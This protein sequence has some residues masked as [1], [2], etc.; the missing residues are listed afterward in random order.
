MLGKSPV[1]TLKKVE[2]N[3]KRINDSIHSNSET[4]EGFLGLAWNIHKTQ[5]K[6]V[7]FS[8]FFKEKMFLKKCLKVFG[9]DN[10][11][12]SV[13]DCVC[14]IILV[15]GAQHSLNNSDTILASDWSIVRI[16]A[17]YWSITL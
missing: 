14:D 9:G 8:K 15:P 4:K 3:E 11:I 5:S 16:P 13:S 1:L 10:F 2:D 12:M 17:S 7:R 6:N